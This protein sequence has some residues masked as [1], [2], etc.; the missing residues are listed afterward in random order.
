M[1]SCKES[2][3]MAFD[4]QSKCE[5]NDNV[6]RGKCQDANVSANLAFDYQGKYMLLK[7]KH[8]R[9]DLVTIWKIS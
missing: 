6:L 9:T 7:F 2:V 5:F 4:Y 3:N 1:S 8:V